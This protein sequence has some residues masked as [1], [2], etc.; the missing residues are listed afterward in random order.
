MWLRTWGICISVP[1]LFHFFFQARVSC[2]PDWFW[3]VMQLIWHLHILILIFYYWCISDVCD[4]YECGFTCGGKG[5]VNATVQLAGLTSNSP[6]FAS[7]LTITVLGFRVCT[8]MLGFCVMVGRGR[9]Q[10]IMQARQ[11][12]CQWSYILSPLIV[13][14]S[15]FLYPFTYS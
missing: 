9:N 7:H 2:S 10:A 15:Y 12:L 6:V 4:V 13:C 5:P 11:E 14:V 8:V 3:L 1:I